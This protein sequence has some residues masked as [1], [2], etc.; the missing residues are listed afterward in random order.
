MK[1]ET[2]KIQRGEGY[3]IINKSDLKSGDVLF[4]VDKP[5]ETKKPVKKAKSKKA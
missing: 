2:V 4:G 5:V 3:V 1:L